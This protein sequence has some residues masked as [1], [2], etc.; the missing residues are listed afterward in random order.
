VLGNID[1]D[2]CSDAAHTIPTFVHFTEVEDGLMKQSWSGRVYLNPPYGRNIAPWVEKLVQQYIRRSVTEAIALVPARVDTD[3]FRQFRD[4]AVCFVDGRLK[5]SG[6]ENSAP[7]PSAVVYLGMDIEK[8]SS[9]F[10][11]IGD[12][13]VRWTR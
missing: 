12:I 5:F 11:D 2:P 7:S 13:W 9:A 3:W 6:H 1:L 4:Y 10:S 8:F